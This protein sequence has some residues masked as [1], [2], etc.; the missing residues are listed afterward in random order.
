MMKKVENK[1]K[2]TLDLSVV[3]ELQQKQ[4]HFDEFYKLSSKYML[5]A[6]LSTVHES[7]PVLTTT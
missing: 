1:S 3:T 4:Q 6:T 7:F 5:G 2:K